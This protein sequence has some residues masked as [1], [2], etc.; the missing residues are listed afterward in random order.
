MVTNKDIGFGELQSTAQL[1]TNYFNYLFVILLSRS[2]G[3]THPI[4]AIILCSK[5]K[6]PEQGFLF[7]CFCK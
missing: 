2:D 3:N 1:K 5:I 7:V 6:M 4:H